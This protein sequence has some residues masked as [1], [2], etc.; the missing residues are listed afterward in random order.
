MSILTEHEIRVAVCGLQNSGKTVFLTALADHLLHHDPDRTTETNRLFDL[1]DY[2][3]GQSDVI[4]IHKPDE[5][6]GNFA[7]QKY[8]AAF[9]QNTWPEKTVGTSELVL[10]LSLENYHRNLTPLRIIGRKWSRKRNVRIR[11]LDVPGER[12][13][14]FLMDGRSFEEWSDALLGNSKLHRQ[15]LD[16]Y[17]EQ[18]GRMPDGLD[19]TCAENAILDAYR[20]TLNEAKRNWDR[21]VTPSS[22]R[23]PLDGKDGSPRLGLADAEFAPMPA[24]LRDLYPELT[25]KFTERYQRYRDT[26]VRPISDWMRT[27]DRALVLV[28]MFSCLNLGRQAYNGSIAE[29]E[30]ALDVLSRGDLLDA[31]RFFF[32][33]GIPQSRVPRDQIRIVVT[34]MDLADPVGQ[35]NMKSLARQMFGKKIRS[36]TGF[37]RPDDAILSCAAV[38]TDEKREGGGETVKKIYKGI[39]AASLDDIPGEGIPRHIPKDLDNWKGRF[40]LKPINPAWFNLPDDLPPMHAGLNRIA[41]FILGIPVPPPSDSEKEGVSK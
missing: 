16:N 11:F 15:H 19:E 38:V 2:A 13:A 27:A 21:F 12:L 9:G 22:F 41:C 1:G 8:R 3:I 28:D 39:G 32:I 4:D 36:V 29:T 10:D 33:R 23:I 7:Y 5:S 37:A 14:D 26:I 34:K 24:K 17:C 35:D 18:T 31:V 30:A 25:K 20:N 40:A 6:I